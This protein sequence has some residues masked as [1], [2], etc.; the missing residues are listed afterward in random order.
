M[1]KSRE[2]KNRYLSLGSDK[3]SREVGPQSM[4]SYEQD[5][6]P[7]SEDPR[8]HNMNAHERHQ[9]RRPFTRHVLFCGV[10]VTTIYLRDGSIKCKLLR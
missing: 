9:H 1:V 4:F 3:V 6:K 2:H 5:R 7:R 8:K 10:S